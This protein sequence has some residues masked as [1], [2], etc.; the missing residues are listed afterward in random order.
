MA[1]TV[2]HSKLSSRT[3][4]RSFLCVL[5]KTSCGWE[6]CWGIISK[7]AFV[8]PTSSFSVCGSTQFLNIGGIPN[9]TF[10]LGAVHKWHNHWRGRRGLKMTTIHCPSFQCSLVVPG[11]KGPSTM[12]RSPT[13]AVLLRN[14][15]WRQL[16]A[17]GG[18][19]QR[20]PKKWWRYSWT[21]PYPTIVSSIKALCVYLAICVRRVNWHIIW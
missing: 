17:H 7:I 3:F 5:F 11:C 20:A 6:T 14:Q 16:F 12:V 18:G 9:I 8:V 21:A 2:P 4:W 13:Y 1:A 15:F 19:S 10:S